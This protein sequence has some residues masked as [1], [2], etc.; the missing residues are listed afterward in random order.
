MRATLVLLAVGLLTPLSRA[1]DPP[2]EVAAKARSLA[3]TFAARQT[4]TGFKVLPEN[5][6]LYS[7][8]LLVTLP[9]ASLE[10]KN[11]AVAVKSLADYDGK[12]PLPALETAFTLNE[13]KEVDLD[14]TLDRGRVDLTSLKA[15]ATVRVRF[16]DQSWK[17]SLDGKGTRVALELCG[18]WPAGSRF[19]VADKGADKPPEPVASLVMLVLNGSANVDV[20]GITLGLKAPPGPAFVEWDSVSGTRPQ[21]QKLDK[22][23]DWADPE[24]SLSPEARKMAE[25]IEKFRKARA[26]NAGTALNAF[27]ESADPIEQRIALVTLG[28]TDDLEPLGKSLRSARNPEQWDFGITIVR[29]WLGRCPGHDQKL[30][31][32]LTSPAQGYSPTTARTI[33]Q[34]LFG[35]EPEDL[36]QPETFEVL[37]EYLAH[38]QAPIRNLAAWHLVRLV[39]QGKSIAFKPNGTKEDADA[40][41]RAWKKLIP[42][43]KLPPELKKG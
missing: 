6:D 29:H 22:L 26:E 11:G 36:K 41:Y 7:S 4:G 1:D 20:G 2:R 34:L 5:A 23:P 39:P 25:A 28:A 40:S 12:S 38:D 43:G 16:W 30:Y 33:M 27:L 14:L 10:S 42:P 37:I 24:T 8:D 35:F 31:A 17:I 19:K 18:R 21:P 15:T 13:A 3:A 32:V 9:G